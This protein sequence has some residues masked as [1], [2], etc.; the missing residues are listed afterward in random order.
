MPLVRS[1][2]LSEKK[3]K[4]AYVEPIID[5]GEQP[6]R[7]R[8]EVRTGRDLK[9][10]GTVNRRGAPVSTPAERKPKRFYGEVKLNPLN[11]PLEL[12]NISEHIVQ[13]LAPLGEVKITLTI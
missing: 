9:E 2:W 10:E 7:V 12:K 11:A 6:P 4:E 13:H 1:F 5:R 8:F 3:D